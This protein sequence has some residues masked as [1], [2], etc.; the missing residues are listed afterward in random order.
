M[1]ENDLAKFL[2]KI[3]ARPGATKKSVWKELD[4]QANRWER[5]AKS[6]GLSRAESHELWQLVGRAGSILHF[7]HHGY[8]GQSATPEDERL[9]D[10]IRALPPA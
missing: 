9:V 1:A 10:L 3:I 2:E 7:F 4:G 6:K 8:P 5:A